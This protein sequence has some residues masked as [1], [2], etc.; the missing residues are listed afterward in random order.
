MGNDVEAGECTV[1]SEISQESHFGLLLLL[2]Q[3]R[4]DKMNVY[5]LVFILLEKKN[6]LI[7]LLAL[8]GVDNI[9]NIMMSYVKGLILDKIVKGMKFFFGSHTLPPSVP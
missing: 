9:Q 6:N 1:H 5:W 8:G 4:G 3:V 7:Q 2:F